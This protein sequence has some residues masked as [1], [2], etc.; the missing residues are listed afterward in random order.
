MKKISIILILILVNIM[1]VNAQQSLDKFEVQ[2]DGLGCPF[3]AYGLEKKFKEFKGIKEVKIDIETGNFTF[4]YPSE[5]KL[6]LDAVEKQV[7]KAGYTPIAGSVTRAN[8]NIEAMHQAEAVQANGATTKHA[9]TRVAGNCEMCKARIEKAA[10]QHLGVSAASWNKD[11]KLLEVDYNSDTTSLEAI[12]KSIANMGHD[13]EH[14]QAH[15]DAY[16]NLPACCHYERI[17]PEKVQK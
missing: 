8:G 11:T 9:T 17:K 12:E 1:T 14:H 6:G 3:C 7:I 15:Q 5:A 16:E 4:A 13:T 10:L 2:V